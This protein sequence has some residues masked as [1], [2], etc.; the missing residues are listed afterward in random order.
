MSTL[1]VF[2][3]ETLRLA[4]LLFRIT[5]QSPVLRF[6]TQPPM[7]RLVKIEIVSSYRGI[8]INTGMGNPTVSSA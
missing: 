3:G 1:T 4:S 6:E 2:A 8:F 5:F 7:T